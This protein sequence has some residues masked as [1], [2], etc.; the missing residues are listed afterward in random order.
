MNPA[1][2][3]RFT[4]HASTGWTKPYPRD[5]RVLSPDEVPGRDTPPQEIG[6]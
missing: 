1:Q 4:W 6:D 5:D 3:N 2:P